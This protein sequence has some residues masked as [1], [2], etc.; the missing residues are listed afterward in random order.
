MFAK[1]KHVVI[2]SDQMVYSNVVRRKRFSNPVRAMSARI[3]A[4]FLL[5]D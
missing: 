2:V 4:E 1:L 3:D 5:Q